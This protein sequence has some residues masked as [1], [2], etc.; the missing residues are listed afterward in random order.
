M[1]WWDC[2][3]PP[4]LHPYWISS[5]ALFFRDA[6][7]KA[8]SSVLCSQSSPSSSWISWHHLQTCHLI[9]HPAYLERLGKHWTRGAAQTRAELCCGND[10]ST[11]LCCFPSF[12][13][14]F[15]H[16]RNLWR[17]F[18]A[19]PLG[20]ALFQM[21]LWI[22]W[23]PYHPDLFVHLPGD[24]F[25]GLLKICEPC[26]PFSFLNTQLQHL[27][28]CLLAP[29]NLVYPMICLVSSPL[30]FLKSFEEKQVINIPSEVLK[31]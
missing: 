14:L 26:P 11:P 4:L 24:S 22:P 20:E 5:P 6:V 27:E 3:F 2:T 19:R 30:V 21:P 18:P 12:K 10:L 31:G 1:Q 13:Q 16:A 23:G 28:G 15:T 17:L 8:N 7:R 29:N 25:K 9:V